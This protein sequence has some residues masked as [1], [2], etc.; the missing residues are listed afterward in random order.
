VWAGNR[1]VKAARALGWKEITAHV[2]QRDEVKAELSSIY[3]NLARQELPVK[4]KA[5]EVA[6]LKELHELKN[7][8]TKHGASL[9]K[10]KTPSRTKCNS[11]DRYTQ[12]AASVMGLSERTVQQLARLKELYEL[13]N[14]ETKHGAVGRGGKEKSGH[15]GHLV[16]KAGR[17]AL[18]P[19][20]EWERFLRARWRTAIADEIGGVP[21]P[22]R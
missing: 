7:P 5:R 21:T 16:P 10:G 3:E 8:E 2:L 6:R 22:A 14:P 9:R 20:E 1:R 18:I 15:D 19:R 12:K 17:H 13:R 4:I 11:E